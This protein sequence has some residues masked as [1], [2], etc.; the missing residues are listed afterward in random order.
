LIVHRAFGVELLITEKS[1][2]AGQNLGHEE[3]VANRGAIPGAV[4]PVETRVI[5]RE[6]VR[7]RRFVD[8]LRSGLLVDDR[9]SAGQ[10]HLGAGA[11]VGVWVDAGARC[12]L[13]LRNPQHIGR[14]WQA[15]DLLLKEDLRIHAAPVPEIGGATRTL[16]RLSAHRGG[17]L[18]GC[19]RRARH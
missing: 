3:P 7:G 13:Q 5:D 10:H 16:G 9:E 15:I 14:L 6:R 2:A 17:G 12:H 11:K 8:G 19:A 1:A 4:S 18:G